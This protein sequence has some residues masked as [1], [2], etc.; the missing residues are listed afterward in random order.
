VIAEA[1][2]LKKDRIE[3]IKKKFEEKKTQKLSD[4]EKTI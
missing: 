3:E 2:Q 4:K 1:E